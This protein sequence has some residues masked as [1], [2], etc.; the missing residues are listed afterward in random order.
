MSMTKPGWRGR[1][2]P[3]GQVHLIGAEGG[4]EPESVDCAMYDAVNEVVDC[5]TKYIGLAWVMALK[6]V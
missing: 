1:G 4:Q 3:A 2:G 6:Q 5:E